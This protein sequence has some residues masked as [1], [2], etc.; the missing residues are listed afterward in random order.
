M[1]RQVDMEQTLTR[2]WS[3]ALAAGVCGAVA[4]TALHQLARRVTDDAP[5]MDVLGER[6]IARTVRAAGGTLPMQPTLHRWALAGDLVA[7]SAYY[8]WSPVA[9]APTCGRAPSRWGWRPQA[10]S[11]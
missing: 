3:S 9:A 2:D 8:R 5:R 1:Q 4:L 10:T 7:N 6:A 11:E